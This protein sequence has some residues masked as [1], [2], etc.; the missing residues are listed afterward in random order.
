ME[1]ICNHL[2]R[3]CP[4]KYYPFDAK[5]L[6]KYV[7]GDDYLPTWEVPSLA[8][9]YTAMGFGMKDSFEAY[10]REQV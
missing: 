2:F 1:T 6:D 8:P 3:Y 4:S 5:D 9:L 7:I 10:V